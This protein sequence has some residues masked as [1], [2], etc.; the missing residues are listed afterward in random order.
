VVEA[1]AAGID[2]WSP[3]WYLDP[4]SDAACHMGQLATVKTARGYLLP[5]PVGEYRVGWNSG[6]GMLYAEGHPTEGGL[7]SPDGL[8]DALAHLVGVLRAADVPVPSG[9]VGPNR[10]G[11]AGVRRLDSTVDVHVSNGAEGLAILAGV[12]AVLRDSP[13]KAEVIWGKDGSVETAY[14]LGSLGKKLGRWYDKSVETRTGSRGTWIRPEDQRRYEKSSR[15]DVGELTGEYVR[16]QFQRRFLPLWKASKGVKVA[17]A[18]VLVERV[19]EAVEAG[20]LT[21]EMAEKLSGYLVLSANGRA[22]LLHERTIRRRRSA[23]RELGLVLADGVLQEVEVDLHD[24]LD[25]VLDADVWGQ[26]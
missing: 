11:F 3:C 17:G 21:P 19:A 25:Q 15:R 7:C 6:V 8:P 18:T 14:V 24:V 10:G 2:T 20:E 13:T 12:A 1:V 22:G 4:G 16:S 9:T 5:E 26:G 23:V